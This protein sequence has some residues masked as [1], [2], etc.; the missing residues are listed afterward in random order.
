M[1]L[2]NKPINHN[3]IFDEYGTY[4][5]TV[6]HLLTTEFHY[7]LDYSETL[8]YYKLLYW[9]ISYFRQQLLKH[10]GRLWRDSQFF[11]PVYQSS[12][13][14]IAYTEN[15]QVALSFRIAKP[16]FDLNNYVIVRKV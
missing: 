16:E 15:Q 1:K 14:P 11:I 8:S 2:S 9:D 6:Q 4:R 12:L 7:P 13:G 5:S 10:N 3:Y